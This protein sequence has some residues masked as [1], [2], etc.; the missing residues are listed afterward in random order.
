MTYDNFNQNVW[1]FEVV[2]DTFGL[3]YKFAIPKDFE[4]IESLIQMKYELN[5]IRTR[6]Q[7]LLDFQYNVF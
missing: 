4:T 7:S 1:R 6:R 5:V 3:E 2:T